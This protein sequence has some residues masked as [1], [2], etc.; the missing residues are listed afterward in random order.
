MNYVSEEINTP[1]AVPNSV[2]QLVSTTVDFILAYFFEFQWIPLYY[3]DGPYIP[4]IIETY[5]GRG[6]RFAFFLILV[7]T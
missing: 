1:D 2:W 7:S 3:E 6:C 4:T 5:N